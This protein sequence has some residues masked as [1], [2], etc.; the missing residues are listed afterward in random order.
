MP[1]S[2]H[3]ARVAARRAALRDWAAANLDPAAPF[4]F[5]IG[6]GHGHF[7]AAYAAAHPD[8]CCVG[9]DQMLERVGRAERKRSRA[10][11]AN[12]HFV[13]AAADDFLA[14]LPDSA[15]FREIYLLFP[16]PWPKRRHL[17]H[18]LLQPAL[19]RQLAERTPVGGRLFFRTDHAGYFAAARALLAADPAWRLDEGPWPFETPTVFQARQPIFQSLAATRTG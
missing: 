12:L 13:R 8:R 9:I 7:L 16:D 3:Q 15:R 14:A 5:E 17:K 1:E 10:E 6:S 11:L 18:R 19:L 4:V 2:D